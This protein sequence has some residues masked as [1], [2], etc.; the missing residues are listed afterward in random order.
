MVKKNIGRKALQRKSNINKTQ[1]EQFGLVS[2]DLDDTAALQCDGAK[3]DVRGTGCAL[4]R[5]ARRRSLVFMQ[6]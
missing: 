3:P 1:A 2:M 4:A 6:A 5:S